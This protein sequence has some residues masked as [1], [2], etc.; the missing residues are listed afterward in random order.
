MNMFTESGS[1]REIVFCK[2]LKA[3]TIFVNIPVTSCS[4]KI[5][6]YS[7]LSLVRT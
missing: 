4:C 3:L 1:G 2:K 5:L 7:T 6:I